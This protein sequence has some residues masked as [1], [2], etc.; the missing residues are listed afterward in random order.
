VKGALDRVY[1]TLPG[2]R[3]VYTVECHGAA[4]ALAFED[5]QDPAIWMKPLQAPTIDDFVTVSF[6]S[7]TAAMV[8]VASPDSL[9]AARYVQSVFGAIRSSPAIADC[10]LRFATRARWCSAWCSA[11]R[12]RST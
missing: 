2:P 3:P 12:E 8:H 10:K 5:G 11:P 4:C 6:S 9:L 1:A 7:A